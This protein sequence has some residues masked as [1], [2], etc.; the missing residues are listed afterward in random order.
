MLGLGSD[1]DGTGG[2][3]EVGS[4]VGGRFGG[5][6]HSR[7]SASAMEILLKSITV[8]CLGQGLFASGALGTGGSGGLVIDKAT[9]CAAP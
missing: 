3:G 9:A 8:P 2:R 5:H 7:W 6:V 4:L 1:G